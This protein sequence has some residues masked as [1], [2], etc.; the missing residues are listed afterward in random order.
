MKRTVLFLL[1]VGLITSFT[2]CGKDK[3]DDD[4]NDPPNPM[5][6]YHLLYNKWWYN[7]EQFRGDHYFTPSDSMTGAIKWIHYNQMVTDGTYQWYPQGDS[8]LI[9]IPQFDPICFHFE[10]ITKDTM[11]YRPANELLNLYK[12]NTTKP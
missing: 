7:H 5:G 1:A 8:M 9:S 12:F 4:N 6:Q 10:Y 11:G 3:D 2:F